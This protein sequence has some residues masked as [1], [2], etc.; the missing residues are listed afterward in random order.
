MVAVFIALNHRRL[1]IRRFVSQELGLV[2]AEVKL[3]S[4]KWCGLDLWVLEWGVSVV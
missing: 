4:I 1:E 2:L 3:L